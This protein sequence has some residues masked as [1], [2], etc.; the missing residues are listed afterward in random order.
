MKFKVREGYTWRSS[1]SNHVIKGP[2]FVE[3]DPEHP[4]VTTQIHKLEPLDEEAAEGPDDPVLFDEEAE[5]DPE[6]ED[7]EEDDEE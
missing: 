1:Q 5:E 4:D 3:L 7:Q 6:V 2:G